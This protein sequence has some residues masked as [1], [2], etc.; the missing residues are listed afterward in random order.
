MHYKERLLIHEL[1]KKYNIN[2]EMVL[3]LLKESKMTSYENV[4]DSEK[5]SEIEN[6]ISFYIKMEQKGESK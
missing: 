1:V 4:K 6:L 5:I 2:S 3:K